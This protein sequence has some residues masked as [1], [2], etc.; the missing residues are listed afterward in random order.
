MNRF[1]I[2]NAFKLFE[3][4]PGVSQELY[5]HG[6]LTIKMYKP[7]KIDKQKPHEQD[8]IYVIAQGSGYFV[9]DDKKTKFEVGEVLFAPANKRHHFEGFTSNF[10]TWVFF[11]GSSGGELKR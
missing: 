10:A 9:I 2:A 5:T 1:T 4:F 7:V 3:D 8:E 6:S 11:Y